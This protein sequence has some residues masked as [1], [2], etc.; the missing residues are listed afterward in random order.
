VRTTSRTTLD[1]VYRRPLGL[2][3]FP[4]HGHPTRRPRGLRYTCGFTLVEILVV[5]VILA[6]IA[7]IAVVVGQR[8]INSAKSK[9]TAATFHVL[10]NAI[11]QFALD[12]PYKNVVAARNRYGLYPPDELEAF[13]PPPAPG[14]IPV[15]P[16]G[17]PPQSWNSANLSPRTSAGPGLLQVPAGDLDNV[18]QRDVKAL[19]L[20]IRLQ[21]GTAA[22]E[23][24]RI[25]PRFILPA[26]PG[27]YFDLNADSTLDPEDTPL[28][29]LVDGWGRPVEY[30]ALN[31]KP[32]PAPI[33][34]PTDNAAG[35]RLTFAPA[36]VQRNNN[37]PFLVSYGPDGD[38]Q[39]GAMQSPLIT[40]WI[41]TTPMKID[42]PLNTDNVY[43]DDSLAARLAGGL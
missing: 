18:K 15:P 6:V 24:E 10:K 26:A 17:G 32:T 38:D 43:S 36:A 27:E 2:R 7:T 14:G 5:I 33:P 21:G 31:P 4:P 41:A 37:V 25:D 28:D 39:V 22:G 12:G 34:A 9:D 19:L 23:L 1:E 16:P 13:T 8:F 20:A 11:D 42:D 35:D 29:A 3:V 40:D 30:F